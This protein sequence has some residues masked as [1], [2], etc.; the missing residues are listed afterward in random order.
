MQI[1]VKVTEILRNARRNPEL[2]LVY[3]T[4]IWL[5]FSLRNKGN[6]CN[7]GQNK[8]LHTRKINDNIRSSSDST[9]PNEANSFFL[10]V[11]C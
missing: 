6:Q 7:P 1:R 9:Q 8:L 2:T 11:N 4:V 3:I 5:R 10:Y